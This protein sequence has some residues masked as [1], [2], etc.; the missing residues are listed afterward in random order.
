M[1]IVGIDP[2]AAGGIAWGF[3]EDLQPEGTVKMPGTLK[4]IYGQLVEIIDGQWF[5]TIVYI[6]KV[7][8]YMPGNSGPSAATFAEHVGALKM[9]LIALCVPHVL[10]PP[11]KWMDLFIGKQTYKEKKKDYEEK[12][13]KA[14][15]AKRKQERKNK[16]KAE[17]Q[18]L[19]PSIKVTL[20]KADALGIWH[21]GKQQHQVKRERPF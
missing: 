1:R 8:T 7:G 10:V 15:L 6:E 2:G 3:A 20:A 12:A 5:D 21:Y 18:R 13:W 19:Y 9:A 4:D 14:I 17:A 16:I 11:K